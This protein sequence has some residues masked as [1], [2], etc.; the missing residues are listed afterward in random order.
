VVQLLTR[1][2]LPAAIASRIVIVILFQISRQHL[3]CTQL[4]QLPLLLPLLPLLAAPA[5]LLQRLP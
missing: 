2:C 1:C 4:L 3:H 5:A